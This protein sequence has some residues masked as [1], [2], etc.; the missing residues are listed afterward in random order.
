MND[1]HA[2][3]INSMSIKNAKMR[4]RNNNKTLWKIKYGCKLRTKLSGN[5]YFNLDQTIMHAIEAIF[6]KKPCNA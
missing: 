1:V 4:K 2:N 3:E 5:I 6:M